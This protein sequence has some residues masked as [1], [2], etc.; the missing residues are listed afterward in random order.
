MARRIEIQLTSRLNDDQW[1]WRAAGARQP[2]GVVAASL[3]PEGTNEGD[4]VKAEVE[5]SIEGLEIVA[6]LK[7]DGLVKTA[8]KAAT[9]ELLGSGKDKA[10]VSWNLSAKSKKGPRRDSRDSDRGRGD[11][12]GSDRNDRGSRSEGQGRGGP[13]SSRPGSARP[14]GRGRPQSPV[15]STDHRNALLATLAPAQLPIAEQLL[16]GGI[17]AVR[18]AIVDQNSQAK[19][20]GQPEASSDAIMVI[21]EKLL[22][23]TSLAMWKDRA[24]TAQSGGKETRLRDLRAVVTAS[25]SVNLD[26]EGKVMAKALQETLD[27]RVKSLSE[28]WV[29]RMTSALE[30]GRVADALMTSARSPEHSTRCPADIA[31][32]LTEKASA[33]MTADANPQ[34]WI[35]LLSAVIESPVRRNVKPSGI[36]SD[37]E[38]KLAAQKAVGQVPALAKLLGL[39]IPPPP[40][41]KVPQR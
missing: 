10:G 31:A 24:S 25:R 22:P 17:P 14:E 28:E 13:R 41:R 7:G 20:D 27:L 21:A 19:T 32:L 23:L 39:K 29:A 1:S 12:R 40:P 9:I 2:K 11:R 8:P 34:E 5:A 33:A 35:A 15:L 36:P 6:V 38:A 26:D 4:V 18:S 30:E 16:R 3:I 37:P